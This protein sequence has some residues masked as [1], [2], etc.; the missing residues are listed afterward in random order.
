MPDRFRR[1]FAARPDFTVC[2]ACRTDFDA[3]SPPGRL[4][5]FVRHAGQISTTA[6]Q[7][8]ICRRQV[9]RARSDFAEKPVPVPE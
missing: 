2:P 5:R 8:L 7:A 9:V 4:H 3:T 6:T 1:H